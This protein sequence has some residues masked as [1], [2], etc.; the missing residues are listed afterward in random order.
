MRKFDS[1]RAFLFGK[2]RQKKEKCTEKE[3][4][5]RKAEAKKCVLYYTYVFVVWKNEARTDVSL[6]M[7]NFLSLSLNSRENCSGNFSRVE[8]TLF[9]EAA[10]SWQ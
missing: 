4:K 2:R 7:K 3:R 8:K 5:K 1:A 6:G 10:H 9:W